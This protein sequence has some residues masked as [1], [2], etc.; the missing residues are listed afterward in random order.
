MYLPYNCW[1]VSMNMESFSSE[2]ESLVSMCFP[3]LRD[4][5][6]STF[7][8]NKHPWTMG[9]YCEELK[10]LFDNSFNNAEKLK[11]AIEASF[12]NDSHNTSCWILLCK[13]FYG[14]CIGVDLMEHFYDW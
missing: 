2:K 5:Q 13:M 1:S 14:T 8:F 9:I 12:D 3:R 11:T 4:I 7:T 6:I 10:A